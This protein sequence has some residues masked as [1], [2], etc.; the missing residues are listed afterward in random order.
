[1]RDYSFLLIESGKFSIRADSVFFMLEDMS[2]QRFNNNILIPLLTKFEE[3]KSKDEDLFEY[4]ILNFPVKIEISPSPRD[5]SLRLGFY[6]PTGKL[7]S[8]IYYF[9]D[10]T[11]NYTSYRTIDNNPLIS[12]CEDNHLIEKVIGPEDLIK[13]KELLDLFKKS[14]VGQHTLSLTHYKQ[15]LIEDLKEEDIVLED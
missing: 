3:A 8:F 2:T 14:W 1:M 12:F 9:F 11:I 6:E 15:K 10:N 13:N 5:S 4:Y 7:Q